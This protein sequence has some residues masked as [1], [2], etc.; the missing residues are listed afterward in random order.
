MKDLGIYLDNFDDFI[1]STDAV[2]GITSTDIKD[3]PTVEDFQDYLQGRNQVFP[4]FAVDARNKYD[5]LFLLNTLLTC[6]E[7][8]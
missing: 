2:I 3:T 6:L 5:V 1:K 4:V 7:I 8:S